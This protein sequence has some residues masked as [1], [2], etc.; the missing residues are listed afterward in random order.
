M[1]AEIITE[2]R[3]VSGRLRIELRQLG[4]QRRKHPAKSFDAT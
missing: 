2:N 1:Y 3:Q 4:M